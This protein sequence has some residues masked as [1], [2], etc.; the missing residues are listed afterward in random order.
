MKPQPAITDHFFFRLANLSTS[1]FG[2]FTSFLS[3]LTVALWPFGGFFVKLWSLFNLAQ[4]LGGNL[5]IL[6][7]DFDSDGRSTE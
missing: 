3:R 1:A 6:F 2:T 5:A 7:I 4:A